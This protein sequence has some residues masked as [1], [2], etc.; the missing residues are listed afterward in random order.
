MSNIIII[1]FETCKMCWHKSNGKQ[2]TDDEQ[3]AP[4]QSSFKSQKAV[5]N[6]C[7]ANSGFFQLHFW[8]NGVEADHFALNSVQVIFDIQS[9]SSTDRRKHELMIK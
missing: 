9:A 7:E 5:K 4:K 2:N 1:I 3:I 6:V 8:R